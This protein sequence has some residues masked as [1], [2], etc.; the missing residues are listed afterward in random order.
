MPIWRGTT[1]NNWSTGSNWDTGIVPTSATDAIFSSSFNVACVVDGAINIFRDC[2]NLTIGSG[3]TSNITLSASIRS[4]NSSVGGI[5]ITING[6]PTFLLG[7][8]SGSLTLNGGATFNRFISSSANVI[9]PRLVSNIA[10]ATLSTSGSIICNNIQFDHGGTTLTIA[11]VGFTASNGTIA[12]STSGL[13]VAAGTPG[14]HLINSID[15]RYIRPFPLNIT[16]A[17]GCNFTQSLILNASSIVINVDST[18]TL[19]CS[20]S[21]YLTFANNCSLNMNGSTIN[22]WNGINLLGTNLTLLS[23]IYLQQYTGSLNT[24]TAV[25]NLTW[26]GTTNTLIGNR[27][28]Y[29]GGNLGLTNNQPLTSTR[30]S[31]GGSKI[32]MYGTGYLGPTAGALNTFIDTDISSSYPIQLGA[33]SVLVNWQLG[34]SIARYITASSFIASNSSSITAGTISPGTIIDFPGQSI[35]NLVNNG[36]IIFL[37]SSLV[38]S[39]SYSVGGTSILNGSTLEIQ[40]NITGPFNA[41]QTGTS[42]ITLG[43]NTPSTYSIL[44]S[45]QNVNINKTAG[46]SVLL[47]N[48]YGLTYSGGTFTYTAGTLNPGT[49]TMTLG[50]STVNGI[51]W[52]NLAVP[53]VSTITSNTANTISNNLTLG[54][55]GNVTFTG[56]AGWTCANLICSNTPRTITLANISTG[57]SYRTTTSASLTATSASRITMVSNNATTRSLWTL[58]YGAQQSLVYVNGTRIDSSLGQ[59]VWTFGGVRTDTVNWNTGSRPGTSAYTFVN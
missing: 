38:C 26:S 11:G 18:A 54:L 56:S 20:S 35:N 1:N 17:P 36:G 44:I 55:T 4:G 34:S 43:G 25:G 40:R 32:V 2:A 23:D 10:N 53:G 29:V 51:S 33:P 50:T 13:I 57:A 21:A 9:I 19:N 14:L 7:T 41:T 15:W 28:I 3:Y 12:G 24:T 31:A 52:Y 49:S 30:F 27:I 42:T 59:T 58:D 48:T 37:S 46:G 6:T 39:G 16:I 8:S 47:G 45:N 22:R 5:G